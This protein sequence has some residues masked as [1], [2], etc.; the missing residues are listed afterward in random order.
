MSW[1]MY[2]EFIKS[3][4]WFIAHHRGIGYAVDKSNR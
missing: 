1:I 3:E 4:E 2:N